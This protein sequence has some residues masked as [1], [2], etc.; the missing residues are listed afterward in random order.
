MAIP[1]RWRGSGPLAVLIPQRWRVAG[2]R[3]VLISSTLAGNRIR[4]P[5]L[6]PPLAG[7]RGPAAVVI[8]N[9][10]RRKLGR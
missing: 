2:P 10:G 6:I 4:L 8:L 7:K 9:A 5:V 1:Q 3:P